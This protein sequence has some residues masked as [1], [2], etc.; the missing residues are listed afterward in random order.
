MR[1]QARTQTPS[2]S[3]KLSTHPALGDWLLRLGKSALWITAS[4]VHCKFKEERFLLLFI[5]SVSLPR[6]GI[7]FLTP[8]IKFD[9]SLV[10]FK[11]SFGL[12]DELQGINKMKRCHAAPEIYN[13][14]LL[15]KNVHEVID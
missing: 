3:Q 6:C 7:Q 8:I 12:T 14:L 2:T 1:S 5:V 13:F 10:H 15:C 4:A 11:G 9:R